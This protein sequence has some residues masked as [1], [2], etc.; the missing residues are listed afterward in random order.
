MNP[1]SGAS[2]AHPLEIRAVCSG[3]T[4]RVVVCGRA[5]R[6]TRHRVREALDALDLTATTTVELDLGELESCDVETAFEVADFACEARDHGGRVV[7]VDA[8]GW[9]V[10]MLVLA[11]VARVLT[12]PGADSPGPT[13]PAPTIRVSPAEVVA[14]HR[15]LLDLDRNDH[16]EAP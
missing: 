2:S 9:A 16:A 13:R 14:L 11:D 10:A 6:S 7:V 8:D 4:T 12:L 1:S 15:L 5:S 3:R